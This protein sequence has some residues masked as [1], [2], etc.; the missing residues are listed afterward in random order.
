MDLK[1][2]YVI[3]KEGFTLN[4]SIKK[5]ILCCIFCVSHGYELIN[6]DEF[7]K[8][9]TI[10]N[11][12]FI[13]G[14][15][16]IGNDVS[17]IQNMDLE[18]MKNIV[19]SNNLYAFNSFGFIKKEFNLNELKEG[20]YINKN[21]N[22]GIYI[23]N[24]LEVKQNNFV[25]LLDKK[26]DTNLF[27]SE[28]N[29]I[30]EIESD[31]ILKV[32]N[33]INTNEH[34]VFNSGN[35]IYFK[36]L[37]KGSDLNNI[38]IEKYVTFSQNSNFGEHNIIKYLLSV[39]LVKKNKRHYINFFP[40]IHPIKYESASI[41]NNSNYLDYIKNTDLKKDIIVEEN[42]SDCFGI[43]WDNRNLLIEYLN[44]F[45]NHDDLIILDN[46]TYK[47]SYLIDKIDKNNVSNKEYDLVINLNYDSSNQ[48]IEYLNKFNIITLLTELNLVD[49]KIMITSK[50]KNRIF[51]TVL[52]YLKINNEV[53]E[54]NDSDIEIVKYMSK[55]KT[56]ISY[57]NLFYLSKIFNPE[58]IIY[59]PYN[60]ENK[61]SYTII[62][63]IKYFDISNIKKSYICGCV[64]NCEKYIDSVFKNID[65]I[66]KLFNETKIIMAY[67]H[68]NDSTLNKL[69][70]LKKRFTNL[71]ILINDNTRSKY[72]THNIANAR[73][74]ILN[75]IRKDDLENEFE[76]FIM[77]DMDDVCSNDVNT[78]ILNLYLIANKNWDCLTF[79]KN[80]YYDIWA[81]S[82]DDLKYS[83]WH[84]NNPDLVIDIMIKHINSKFNNCNIYDF[85][86][87]YSAFCG[88][89]IYRKNK[90]INCNYVSNIF[91][92]IDLITRNKLDENI[93]YINEISKRE[94]FIHTNNLEDC[95]HRYFHMS[96]INKNKA[97][98]K[99]SPLSLFDSNYENNCKLLSSRG[100]LKSC[101]IK[102]VVPA[103]SNSILSYYNFDCMK[104]NNII[105]VCNY[106]IQNFSKILENIPYKIILVSG[107][108]DCTI[109]HDFFK[110]INEFIDNPKIIHWFAQNCTYLH[111]KITG[112]PIGLDYHTMNEKKTDWG[113]KILPIEQ[114]NL[115]VS[116]KNSSK[117]FYDRYIKCYS[118]FH[119]FTKTKHG[120]DRV[121]AIS[122]L[123]PEL[124]DYEKN[125]VDRKTTWETQSKYAFV[126]SP[127]GNGLDC[128]RTWEALCLGCIPV[129]KKSEISYLYDELPVL[130]VED[131]ENISNELLK[132]TVDK[133]KNTKFNYD[134]LNLEYWLKLI[135]SKVV[136]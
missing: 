88:F 109:S 16:C 44:D 108:S 92:S 135:K 113:N 5:Y 20:A 32:I 114:E 31:D 123:K 69:N 39:L 4:S 78:D 40:T 52:N 136:E 100:I 116:I 118:N 112:I 50:I 73:N 15:D 33:F 60:F 64:K 83:C 26:I 9:N 34:Y 59:L 65:K 70:E 81:L 54:F 75:Y 62:E 99:I 49:K 95:E 3:F 63:G 48:N 122:K 46:Q 128:H 18:Y 106:A 30:Y 101:D 42:I 110:G 129:V 12:E 8:T 53:T 51:Y 24:M 125:K 47:I 90:F 55:S 115:L 102:S 134:K 66:S 96:A 127:H 36:D 29:Y 67:D 61:N 120:Y 130:I 41:I 7:T 119:F 45:K 76:Y 82:I 104:D 121:D 117:P 126:I 35:K 56:I 103:S 85:I 37:I 68:S 72:N 23:R 107:D 57:N 131:W 22:H 2:K 71:E 28:E 97:L 19:I 38:G 105:Y 94:N 58:Q 133:F 79:N 14:L 11:F 6:Y 1:K 132:E 74:L 98:I 91:N 87:C 86:D 17:M 124:V 89:G 21:T 10:N 93:K 111:P 84:F 27:F 80:N 25:S 77:L 43:L 13:K